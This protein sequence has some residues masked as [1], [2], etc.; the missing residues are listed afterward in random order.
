MHSLIPISGIVFGCDISDTPR[1]RDLI[2]SIS[3][4]HMLQLSSC[5]NIVIHTITRLTNSLIWELVWSL[6]HKISKEISL[7]T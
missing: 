5:I 2:Y 4:D 7:F 1:T 3:T 6:L